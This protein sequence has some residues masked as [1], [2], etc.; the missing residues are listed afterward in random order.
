MKPL[1][2]GYLRITDDLA[3]HDI[4]QMERRLRE[5]AEAEGFC[6]ATT[7]YES[8]PGHQGAFAELTDELKRA[9]AHHV[10]VLSLDHFS[11]HPILRDQLRAHL[12]FEANAQVWAVEQ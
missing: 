12:E 10:V 1:M 11:P 3:D 8:Q 6:F 2:Y 5:L 9:Q 7:F 4:G